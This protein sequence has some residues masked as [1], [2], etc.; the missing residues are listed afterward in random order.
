MTALKNYKIFQ[1]LTFLELIILYQCN[2]DLLMY[3]LYILL[4]SDDC[5]IHDVDKTN[6]NNS[7]YRNDAESTQVSYA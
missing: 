3:E 4:H 1:R 5:N 2:V 6:F 7:Y